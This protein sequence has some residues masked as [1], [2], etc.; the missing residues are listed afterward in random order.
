MSPYEKI[1]IQIVFLGSPEF[2]IGI[3]PG[4]K[5]L[6]AVIRTGSLDPV[7]PR[8]IA[9]RGGVKGFGRGNFIGPD[10]VNMLS[11]PLIADILPYFKI[12]VV[13]CMIFRIIFDSPDV[14][15]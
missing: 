2:I 13:G 9:R 5:Y 12:V 6:G 15:Q 4:G 1:G 11:M 10:R 8:D 7:V 3:S 14:G